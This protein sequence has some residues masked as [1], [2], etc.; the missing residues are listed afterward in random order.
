MPPSS[1]LRDLHRRDAMPGDVTDV[2]HVPIEPAE[3]VQYI[4]SIYG[5]GTYSLRLAFVAT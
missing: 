5:F 1:D 3:A 2:V 4:I